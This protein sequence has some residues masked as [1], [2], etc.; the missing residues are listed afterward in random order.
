M[1]YNVWIGG[2]TVIC[3][4][5]NIGS[6]VVIGAGSVVTKDIPDWCVA[7]GNPCRVKR[8]ITDDDKK[9]CLRMKKLTKKHGIILWAM[10]VI[11][12]F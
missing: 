7:V 3:P 9:N 6:N 2:N 1:W 11:L 4:G 5:V 12:L 8:L 10:V